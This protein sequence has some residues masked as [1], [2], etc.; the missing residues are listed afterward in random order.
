M[1]EVFKV[2][3]DCIAFT[4]LAEYLTGHKRTFLQNLNPETRNLE[5][6]KLRWMSLPGHRT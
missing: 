3:V 5:S 4:A 2:K 1:C 6:F